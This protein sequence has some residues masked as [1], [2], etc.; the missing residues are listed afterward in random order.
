MDKS[1][2]SVISQDPD[3]ASESEMYTS[4]LDMERKLDWTMTR[5]RMEIQDALGGAGAG[6]GGSTGKTPTTTRTLRVFMSYTTS[7]QVWQNQDGGGDT[8]VAPAWTFKLDGRLLEVSFMSI[9]GV[10]I[11][12]LSF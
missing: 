2:P 8:N 9:E 5:K 6:S 1:L 10:C 12:V 3:F 11:N 7:N 4:L